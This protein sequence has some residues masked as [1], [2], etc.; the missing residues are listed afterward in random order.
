VF[1]SGARSY[2]ADTPLDLTSQ[3]H[4]IY[5]RFGSLLE[6]AGADW[7]DTVRVRQFI[8]DTAAD[9]NKVRDGRKSFVPAGRF[10]STS[11]SCLP[12]DPTGD[13]GNWTI[14]VDLEGAC[15]PKVTVTTSEMVD[16]PGVPHALRVG[17]LVHLQAELANDAHDKILYPGDVEAQ[18][19]HVLGCLDRMLGAAGC[20]WSDVVTSRIF[21]KNRE[22]IS[23]VRRI[24][25]AW[26]GDS[27]YARSDLVTRFFDRDVLLEIEL[28]AHAR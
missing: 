18:A 19:R 16:T 24:E 21:Y 28:V 15:A 25:R 9:F 5:R 26:A 1:L 7:R 13:L 27:A 12:D 14:A 10:V 22:D 23:V 17:D 4:D 6:E 3:T 8:T 2:A 11:V 20:G